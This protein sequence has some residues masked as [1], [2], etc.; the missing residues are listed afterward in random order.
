M[1]NFLS[2]WLFE[3][4]HRKTTFPLTRV[5]NTG[6]YVACLECGKEFPYNWQEM[7]IEGADRSKLGLWSQLLRVSS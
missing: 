5:R 4:S 2:S 3:C 1:I 6:A 7:R